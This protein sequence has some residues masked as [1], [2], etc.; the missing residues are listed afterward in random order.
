MSVTT[1]S[2]SKWSPAFL[3]SMSLKT[4][5]EAEK[6]IADIAISDNFAS[7]RELFKSLDS[8]DDTAGNST[9][10]ASVKNYFNTNNH[11]PAW[12]DQKK[13]KIAQD[14]FAQYGPEISLILN[15]KALPL[16]YSCRN[17][18]K[19]LATTGRL[20]SNGTDTRKMMRRL[21][22]TAQMVMNVMTEGGLEEKGAGIVTVKKV[23]LYHAAIRYF[24][25]HPKYNPTGWDIKKY[26]EPINQEELAGTLTSF[27]ALIING[28]TQVDI[29]LTTEQKDAYMHTWNIVGHFIGLDP[30]LYPVSYQDGWDLGIAVIKRNNEESADGKFLIDS[31]IMNSKNYFFDSIINNYIPEYLISFFIEDV[32]NTINVD[33]NKVLGLDNKF[34]FLERLGGKAFLEAMELANDVQEHAPVVKRLMDKY[35]SKQLQAMIDE[36]LKENK[37]AFYIPNSLKDNWKMN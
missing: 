10:P 12:A 22:E 14:V 13:I 4:D 34:N 9:L 29:Q 5:P 18:A 27:S 37:V 36:Y 8:N 35:S 2:N 24:I 19:I 32:A 21:L 7:L 11:L 20:S 28:L 1:P 17:G 15:Y 33:L 25:T 26:G 23:R 30:A 16:C 6:I 31:L 3:Q